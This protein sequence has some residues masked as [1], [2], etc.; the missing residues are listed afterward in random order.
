MKRSKI[1][2]AMDRIDEDL[3]VGAMAEK[4]VAARAPKNPIFGGWR[5][6]RFAAV[7]A[8]GVLL[9]GGGVA[10]GQ[11]VG[12]AQPVAVVAFDVNPSLE[13][14]VNKKEQVV[15]VNVF[16][17]DAKKIVGDMNL[18][19][20]DLDVAVNALVGSMLKNGYLSVEQNSILISVNA[21]NDGKAERMRETLSVDI[22][23]LLSG[24]NIDACVITQTFERGEKREGISSAKAALIEKVLAA[25]LKTNDGVP[26]AYEKLA[27]LKVHEL[28]LILQSKG[29]S[30]EGVQT[31]GQASE[32]SLIG[33]ENALAIA[34]EQAGV[35]DGDTVEKLEMELDFEYG[36]M[37][38]EVE[39]EYG[40]FEYEYEING[41]TGT[42]LEEE[43]EPV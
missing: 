23:A 18:K 37:V 8:A 9:I 12:N 26:Y 14:E 2:S 4:P 42:I 32:S 39:F 1:A 24:S 15:K 6:Q 11:A 16:N 33:R 13:I 3:L 17:E 36:V 31:S 40:G 22:S 27:S 35:R 21:K 20:V 5:W 10:T 25:G 30:L 7:A 43:R 19:K 29:I 34:Y 41:V 28:K 38:Y